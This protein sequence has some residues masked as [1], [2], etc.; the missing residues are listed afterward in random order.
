MVGRDVSDLDR[1]DAVA[2]IDEFIR[3]V[4]LTTRSP[5]QH[6]RLQR[7]AR[8]PVTVAGFNVLSTIE[9]H[10]PIAVS[11]LATRLGIDQSTASRQVGTL[12]ELGL[13]QRRADPDDGRVTRLSASVKGRRALDRLRDAALNDYAAALD[14]W[15]EADRETLARLLD[16]LRHD[17]LSARTDESGWSLRSRPP[18]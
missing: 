7:I 12:D 16:R 5:R 6:E 1:P 4:S 15:S 11:D 14:L 2:A 3:L 9:R 18:G 17:L 8:V 10:A 13:V